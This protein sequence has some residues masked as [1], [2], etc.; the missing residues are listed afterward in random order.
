MGS[1]KRKHSKSSGSSGATDTT[2]AAAADT[3]ANAGIQVSVSVLETNS[4]GGPVLATFAGS[5]PPSESVF[6]TFIKKPIE[7]D[8]PEDTKHIV[9]TETERM[10]FVGKDFGSDGPPKGR[11][12]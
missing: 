11:F 5:T 10:E 7:E 4:E 12:Q 3:S 2:V 1:K 6:R 9:V 8:S